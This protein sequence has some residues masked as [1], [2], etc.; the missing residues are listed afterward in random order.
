MGKIRCGTRWAV[1]KREK[2]TGH[3]Y[4]TAHCS[5]LVRARSSIIMNFLHLTFKTAII[6]RKGSVLWRQIPC[7]S[8]IFRIAGEQTFCAVA[9][10][11][12]D[13]SSRHCVRASVVTA[14]A[15]RCHSYDARGQGDC[16]LAYRR[17]NL[18]SVRT[19]MTTVECAPNI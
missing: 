18:C 7:A 8:I 4:L 15:A 11:R 13:I 16:F 6:D 3:R 17:S 9:Q 5:L 10:R 2:L 19:E 1:V 14:A 12:F